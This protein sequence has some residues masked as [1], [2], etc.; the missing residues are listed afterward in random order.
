MSVRR[1]TRGLGTV[2]LITAVTIAA[3]IAGAAKGAWDTDGVRSLLANRVVEGRRVVGLV[4]GLVDP[5]GRQVIAGGATAPGGAVVPTADTIFE[6]GSITKVFTSLILADMAEKGEIEPETPVAN[7]LPAGTKIPSRNGREINLLDL[8]TQDSGL[9]RLPD[10]LKPADPGNPYVDYGPDRLYAFLAGY[11]LPRDP[12]EKYEY[13]N[14][15]VGLLG[16]ALSLRA[17]MSYEELVRKRILVPLE[18]NDT[19]ITLSDSERA[20]LAVG[21]GPDL[22]PVKNW[23][24]D[25]LAGAGAIKSTAN[26]MMKFLEAAMGIKDT[27]LRPAFRRLLQ[28]R[29]PT[30]VPDLDIAMGWHIWKKF[31]TDIEWHNGGTGGYRSFAGFDPDRKT[32]VVVLCNTA[33]GVDDIGLHALD[34]RYEAGR[35]SA[36]REHKEVEVD[37]ALLEACVGEYELGPGTIMAVTRSGNRLFERVTGQAQFVLFPESPTEFFLKAVDVQITFIKDAK[38]RVTGLVIHQSGLDRNARKIK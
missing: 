13:S 30:G 10:N 1:N 9:P 24:F 33:F 37:A 12:G 16:Q 21:S 31:G 36:P 26:D 15:G 5:S 22:K 2:A 34:A 14:L 20:R 4:V 29:R 3:L 23:D 38:G 7:Y 32:G 25:A 19:G 27:P 8:S 6:I 28:T 35:F 18:M 11:T 17:G